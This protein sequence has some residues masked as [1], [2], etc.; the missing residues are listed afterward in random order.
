[1][2][3]KKKV[4]VVARTEADHV[5]TAK[6]VFSWIKEGKTKAQMIQTQIWGLNWFY[7]KRVCMRSESH[8]ENG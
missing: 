7:Q 1:M 4:N 2:V 6:T 8:C 3:Q 5:R